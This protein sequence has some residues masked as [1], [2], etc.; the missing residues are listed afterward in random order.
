[1]NKISLI[2]ITKNE[3]NNIVKWQGW[4]PKLK[5]VT[6]LVCVDDNSTDDT[7]E[8]VKKLGSKNL[9]VKV[10]KREL[11]HNFSNQRQFAVTKTTNDWV[12]WLDA[13]EYPSDKLVH[14]INHIDKYLYYNYSFRRKDIFVGHTLKHGETSSQFFLRLFNKNYG[15]FS[16]TVH[17][18]W[19]S[20]NTTAFIK[21]N[22]IH[23]SHLT[24]QS[25]F[26][27]IN[28]YSDLR[29]KELFDQKITT[30]L[31]QIIFYPLAKFIYN[32][33]LRLGFLDGT[34]GIIIALGMSFHSFLVRAKLWCLSNP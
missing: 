14:Y 4:L 5:N 26:T 17:E 7:I 20:S 19:V 11:N 16:G 31:F 30:N 27:K 23:Q 2:L 25:F 24:L 29:S 9:T 32:Y 3:S 28:Y 18:L 6:E 15:Y 33:F 13:D 1:M 8:Q 21:K 22:I 10:F 34:A 12:L